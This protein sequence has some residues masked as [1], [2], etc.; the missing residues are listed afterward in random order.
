MV[1]EIDWSE[2]FLPMY[3]DVITIPKSTILWRGCDPKYP[4]ISERPAY[5]GSQR[6]AQGYADKYNTHAIPFITTR[7]IELIDIRFMIVLLKQLIENNVHLIK[8]KD[9]VRSVL[10][11]FGM[12]SLSHQ[13]KLFKDKYK[14]IYSL[15]NSLYDNLK[16]GIQKLET[17]LN[18]DAIYEQPGCRIAE[19][20]NDA[21]V[22]GFLKG[23]F[24]NHC[25]GYV[26]PSMLSPFHIE[27]SNFKLNSEII[28]FTPIHSGLKVLES[29]PSNIQNI[30]IHRFILNRQHSYISINLQNI[31]MP[32][33]IKS[34]V[35][36]R[37][38]SKN[39]TND[40][41]DDYNY[42]YDN[43]DKNI[44]KLYNYGLKYGMKWRIK[45]I[46]IQAA[47]APVPC[48]DPSIFTR[49]DE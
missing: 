11:S 45:P 4:I 25:D 30:T 6:I 18:K 28:L 36:K 26:S 34:A 24:F 47:I 1:Y 22:M 39:E 20:T 14:A 31:K 21:I 9:I 3:G 15:S 27:K 49:C 43:G 13:I 12:C 7:D 10:I 41:C 32:Y 33:Y 19:T 16:L 38:G 8:D 5:Y 37:G 35:D 29:M 48:V 46:Q 44:I 17:F 40:V 42:L 23:L 2:D